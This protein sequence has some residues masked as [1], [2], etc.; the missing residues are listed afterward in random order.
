MW[1]EKDA[2]ALAARYA[3]E[4]VAR[5]VADC[6]Y[7]TRLLGRDKRLVLHGGG[8]SSVKTRARDAAGAERDVLCV[9]ASGADM[10]VVG[11]A[12]LP[13]LDLDQLRR[14]RN[15]DRLAEADMRGAQR[16]CLLDG[17]AGDPSVETLLHAF[18]PHKFIAHCHANAVLSVTNQPDG[19]ALSAALFAGRAAV[20][21][22]T[23]S[24]LELAQRAAEAF[25]AAPECGGL[26]LMHHGLVSFADDARSAYDTMLALVARAEAHI[27]E[28]R[29]E[30]PPA[31]PRSGKLMAVAEVAAILRGAL[32][33]ASQ[34]AG[35]PE[36][37]D[38]QVLSFRTSREIL[39]YLDG[40]EMAR[41]AAAGVAT[42]D[43]VIR[44]KNKPLIVSLI[45]ATEGSGGGDS[46]RHSVTI[47]VT[48]YMAAYRAY[49][50]RH[51]RP[52]QDLTAL[53]DARPRVALVPGL[54][55]FGIGR[56]MAQA[57]IIADIAEATM[58]VVTG[59][60]AIDRYQPAAEADI[61]AIESWSLEQAKLRRTQAP[62][63]GQV[64]VISGG[65]GAIGA[66][67]ARE[68][69]AAG[70]ALAV[71]DL[72]GGKAEEI[73]REFAAAGLGLACDV[74]DEG[75]VGAAF[76][77]VCETFGG[78]DILIS[79]AGA[80]WQGRIGEVAEEVLRQSFELN[81]FA[82]QRLAQHAVRLMQTQGSGGCL[83]FNISKQ[84]INPGADFGPYGLPKAATLFLM[85][86]YALDHG[87]DGIRANAVN[88]DRIRSGLLS[89]EMIAERAAARGLSEGE[90][91]AGNLLGREVTAEDVARAFLHL[92]LASKTTGNVT[93]VD[94]GNIAAMLR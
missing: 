71:L 33:R 37:A 89:A 8:N 60:E 72:D 19:E 27:A 59:A 81:F 22:Y 62:L 4:G 35:D 52:G 36:S 54:G 85:R 24:G 65:A 13:A 94:G 39:H 92:A 21:P 34:A 41:Y 11:P 25:E 67:T 82:H 61:F 42:P 3:A 63:A 84:A 69:A 55:L 30:L 28:T 88:A 49:L 83:L 80:A 75:S 23:M 17:G 32:A 48:E 91:M 44:T 78:V 50:A 73:A 53:A 7:L 79:N 86:Q 18:L 56:S 43:H 90:Y 68:F 14:L 64:V 74:T 51:A 5:D 76:K 58:D 2:E 12:D 77:R 47:A 66:A 9:K 31:K 93:T 1:S 6:L 70:A 87:R 46:F 26:V 57:E 40:A 16:A 20:V 38:R 45:A 10:A 29:R 15:L